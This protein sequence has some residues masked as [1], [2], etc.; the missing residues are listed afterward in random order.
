MGGG[1]AL[2]RDQGEDLRRVQSRGVGGG[3]VEEGVDRLDVGPV[4]LTHPAGECPPARTVTGMSRTY[5]YTGPWNHLGNPAASVPIGLSKKGMP[6]AVLEARACGVVPVLSDINLDIDAGDPGE[7]LLALR[8]FG[9]HR[10]RLFPGG[11]ESTS[12]SM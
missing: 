7:R 8:A 9:A 4:H 2:L 5:P 1:A 12:E 3:Q 11:A 10:L 6:L